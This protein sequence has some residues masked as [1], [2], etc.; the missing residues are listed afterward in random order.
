MLRR[1]GHRGIASTSTRV[2]ALR[3]GDVPPSETSRYGGR[4]S[5]RGSTGRHNVT[6]G[7]A[8]AACLSCIR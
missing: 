5:S 3:T 6:L 8:R 4:A 2:G 1:L 7:T